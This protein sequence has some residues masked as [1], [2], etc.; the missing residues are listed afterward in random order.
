MRRYGYMPRCPD[1][2]WSNE[3]R[4]YLCRAMLEGESQDTV[5]FN[6]HTG[7]GCCAPLNSWR[8]DVRNRDT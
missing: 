4:R 6:Q 7:K 3:Q 5:R 1:L 2:L 8:Q